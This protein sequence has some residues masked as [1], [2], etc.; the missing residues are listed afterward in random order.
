M[1]SFFICL[2][3]IIKKALYSSFYKLSKKIF[4]SLNSITQKPESEIK[5]KTLQRPKSA[6]LLS[7]PYNFHNKQEAV[8]IKQKIK[9]SLQTF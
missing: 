4:H 5:M 1:N 7:L 9:K 6:V 3:T 2:E 8:D